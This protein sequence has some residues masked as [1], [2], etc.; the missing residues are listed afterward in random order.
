[1]SLEFSQ[2]QPLA[3]ALDD[4]ASDVAGLENKVATLQ[5]KG[6]EAITGFKRAPYEA[7]CA[8]GQ[9]VHEGYAHIGQGWNPGAGTFVASHFRT[10]DF[11][12]AEK[13]IEPLGMTPVVM[14]EIASHAGRV[15]RGPGLDTLPAVYNDDLVTNAIWSSAN[16]SAPWVQ[17]SSPPPLPR[18]V[19]GLLTH[20]EHLYSF[21]G[22]A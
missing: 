20:G 8:G 12:V 7:R 11:M 16:G 22:E 9:C 6:V 1:M 15:Y 2:W 14:S 18:E 4:L 21:L 17:E 13:A 3:Q 10:K 19:C 5:Q